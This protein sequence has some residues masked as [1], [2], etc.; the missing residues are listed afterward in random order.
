MRSA[1]SIRKFI[2]PV[3][4]LLLLP[5]VIAAGFPG[6]AMA[7]APVAKYIGADAYSNPTWSQ[8]GKPGSHNYL[9]SLEAEKFFYNNKALPGSDAAKTYQ[10]GVPGCG[11]ATGGSYVYKK[12]AL[13]IVIWN[14]ATS[15]TGA[16]LHRFLLSSLK[17]PHEIIMAFCNEPEFSGHHGPEGCKCDLTGKVKPCGGPT[18]FIKQF[19]IE[20]KYIRSFERQHRASN[21][22]VAEI[23]WGAYYTAGRNGCSVNPTSNPGNFIVPRQYVDYYLV[24]IYE[25]GRKHP[26]TRPE[27]LNQ[28]MA[29]NNWVA[30]TVAS[31]IPRGIAEFAIN[32]GHEQQS[33]H[34]GAY[35]KAV[36]ESLRK[37]DSYLKHRFGSLEVWNLWDFGGCALNNQQGDEPDSVTAWQRIEAGR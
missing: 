26:I 14:M 8:A 19:E 5:L 7:G 2:Y 6:Q 13:C 36:A 24:D 17:D 15:R 32:C 12:S 34:G 31:G 23:S 30:C 37:D 21:V 18:S 33:L 10:F 16:D 1:V 20:A 29:W 27:P 9:G 3:V 25:G 4:L 11:A 22:K 28:N 35:E